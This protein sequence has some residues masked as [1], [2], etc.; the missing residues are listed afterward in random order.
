M[1][2]TRIEKPKERDAMKEAADRP[3]KDEIEVVQLKEGSRSAGRRPFRPLTSRSSES[4]N[5]PP[6]VSVMALERSA[7]GAV[8]VNGYSN[9][10]GSSSDVEMN[11]D[12][13]D[14]DEVDAPSD[15]NDDG[16]P[17][18]LPMPP[19]PPVKVKE[20]KKEKK[21]LMSLRRKRKNIN[22]NCN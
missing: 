3:I 7:G 11:D 8:R 14:D 20:R 5:L 18:D 21:N 4:N 19:S 13:P 22:G 17:A 10:Y 15:D 16:D 2:V 1:Q 6:H 12:L 9:G